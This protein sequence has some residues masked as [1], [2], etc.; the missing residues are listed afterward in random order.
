V[1][2]DAGVVEVRA[3]GRVLGRLSA[4]NQRGWA[5]PSIDLPPDLPSVFELE[6]TRVEGEWTSYHVWVLGGGDDR[7]RRRAREPVPSR[8]SGP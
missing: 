7:A 5:E 2:P 3:E 1:A 8:E 6:L 4:G